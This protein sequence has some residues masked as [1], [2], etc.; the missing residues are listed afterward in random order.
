MKPSLIA[1]ALLGALAF[2]APATPAQRE[3][4][5][6]PYAG[7]ISPA[8]A[9]YLTRGIADGEARNAAAIII[10]LDTPGGLDSSMREIIQREMNS[11]VPVVV[12]VAPGGARAASAGCIIVLGADVAAMAP[13]TNIGAAHPIYSTGGTVSEKIVND[14]AA[15][16]RSIAAAHKR[17]TEWPERAVRESVSATAEEALSL[18]VID[19]T[20]SDLPDL[21]AKLNGRTV[22]RAGGDATLAI[23]GAQ[24]TTIEMDA[25]EKLLAALTEPTVA[26]LFLLLG[27]LAIVVE[28]SAPH[29]FVTGTLGFVAVL[30]ALVGLVN[31]PVQISGAALL[32]LGMVLL[33]LELK[34][35]SHGAL[36]LLGLAAFVFGSIL[37]LPRIPGYGISPF[38]I[39]A[40]ALLWAFMLSFAVRLVLRSRHQPVLTGVE[41]VAGRTGVAKT[42]LVPR[43]VV[44]VNGEDWEGLADAPPIARGERI[45]VVSVEGLTLHV[46][47]T[48]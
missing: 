27:L 14:A 18:G 23:S 12:F 20:A 44:L 45:T 38:A 34:I 35:T 26:Y 22:H 13:G 8:S 1:T 6:L 47:K 32:V 9:E 39:G 5:V 15:Y 3:I 42:D 48:S 4:V 24:T 29:G 30:L 11:R 2:L 19:L 16:A 31:L 17:N 36:T 25:R 46:R 10:E 40:V 43:G 7:P 21:L 33:G 41:R 37:L 28:I